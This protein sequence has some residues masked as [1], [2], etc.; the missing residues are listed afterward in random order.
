MEG[1]AKGWAAYNMTTTEDSQQMEA[2]GCVVS[3]NGIV[4]EQQQPAESCAVA[5]VY[6]KVTTTATVFCASR[7]HKPDV[8]D[9]EDRNHVRLWFGTRWH[10]RRL[11]RASASYSHSMGAGGWVEWQVPHSSII[12]AAI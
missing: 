12:P 8:I 11:L 9:C 2:V 7:L 3:L 10:A 6:W 1:H 5:V 4:Q